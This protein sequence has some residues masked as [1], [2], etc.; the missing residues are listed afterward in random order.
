VLHPLSLW[1]KYTSTTYTPIMAKAPRARS[2]A[3]SE[4]WGLNSASRKI[5]AMP[6]AM[7][8]SRTAGRLSQAPIS[9]GVMCSDSFSRRLANQSVSTPM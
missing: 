1:E 4:S 2:S 7:A 3:L 5:E 9:S 6:M 8:W